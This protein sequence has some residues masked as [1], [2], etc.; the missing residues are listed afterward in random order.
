[1]ADEVLPIP[2]DSLIHTVADLLRQQGQDQAVD[3]LETAEA[4]IEET[5]YDNWNGGTTFYTLS[6]NLPVRHISLSPP[7][8]LTQRPH[9]L[10]TVATT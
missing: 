8:Q 5:G 1:M 4:R 10:L 9:G 3:V 2:L 6:L 7:V